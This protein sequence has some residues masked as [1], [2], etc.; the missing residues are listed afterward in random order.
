MMIHLNNN[1]IEPWSSLSHYEH[2]HMAHRSVR[3]HSINRPDEFHYFYQRLRENILKFKQQ[4]RHGKRRDSYLNEQQISLP[5]E[6][7]SIAQAII[8]Q[9]EMRRKNINIDS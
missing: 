5:L 7:I 2:T 9:S 6:F 4:T 3:S 1:N 8:D